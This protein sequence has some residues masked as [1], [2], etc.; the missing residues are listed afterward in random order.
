M[1]IHLVLI[2]PEQAAGVDG[3]SQTNIAKLY[4]KPSPVVCKTAEQQNIKSS[5]VLENL[6]T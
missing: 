5:I 6:R 2:S 3:R 4:A 1:L